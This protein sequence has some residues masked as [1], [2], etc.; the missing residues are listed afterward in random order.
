M[1]QDKFKFEQQHQNPPKKTSFGIWTLIIS[2]VIAFGFGYGVGF[3]SSAYFRNVSINK[4][5][6]NNIQILQANSTSV[7]NEQPPKTIVPTNQ[8]KIAIQT[9]N[10][11]ATESEIKAITSSL[12]N[13]T[14][15]TK[16][17]NIQANQEPKGPQISTQTKTK[18]RE[19]KTAA[20]AMTETKGNFV[21]Q[22]A[23]F[24]D[25][26]KALNLVISL[27]QKGF[28]ASSEQTIINNVAYTRVIIEAHN[29]SEANKIATKLKADG[30]TNLPII[31]ERK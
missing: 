14:N 1:E 22:V 4:E 8:A 30:I 16:T 29:L 31:Y 19:N 27:I 21:V 18:T 15:S 28:N 5:L 11:N 25:K 3:V 7:K 9:N 6:A 23:S 24:P 13:Q 20:H 17:V 2:I 12:T 10:A 26:S